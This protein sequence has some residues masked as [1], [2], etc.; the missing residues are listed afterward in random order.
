MNP[1]VIPMTVLLHE[2]ISDTIVDHISSMCV[3]NAMYID[4]ISLDLVVERTSDFASVI[5]I[6]MN[7]RNLNSTLQEISRIVQ[8]YTRRVEWF[9]FVTH[10]F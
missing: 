1:V 7:Q 9:D 10:P 8:L 4:K 2:K 5:L 3:A 6:I